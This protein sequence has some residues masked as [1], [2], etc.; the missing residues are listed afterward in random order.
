[1]TEIMAKL[2]WYPDE[3]LVPITQDDLDKISKEY[4]VNISLEEVKGKGA[5]K[6]DGILREK[7]LNLEEITQ[8][9]VT[10]SAEDEEAFRGA[11]REVIK[12]YRAP[13]QAFSLWGS[14]DRGKWI[15]GELSDEEDG[16]F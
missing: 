10:L 13:R 4:K 11:V 1:M 15:V 12:K 16:W 8:S 6:V 14:T 7:T 2:R 5:V 3:P 9:V